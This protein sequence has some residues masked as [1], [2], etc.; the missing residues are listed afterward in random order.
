MDITD[1]LKADPQ[2][3]HPNYFFEPQET[4]RCADANGH[5]HG[6]GS[7]WV[8]HHTYFNQDLFDKAGIKPPGFKDDEI[9][10]RDTFI[11]NAKQLTVDA[12]GKHPDDSR[13]DPDN[14]QQWAVNWEMWWMPIAAAIY[15]NGGEFI[16]KDGLLA[17]DSPE[18]M[19]AMQRLVDLIYV[20]HV[21]PRTASMSDL[22]MTSAQMVDNG[23]LAMAVDGSWALSWLNPAAM[24]VPMGTGAIPKMKKPATV[25]Q[26]HFHAIISSTKHPD[27]AW[28]WLKFLASPFYTLSFMK[29]GLWLPSQSAQVTPDGLKE[30]VTKG[31]HPDNY[32]DFVTEYLPKNGVALRIP[33]GYSEAETSFI[34]PAFQAMSAGTPVA[35]VMP[36]AVK[37]ANEIIKAAQAS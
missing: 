17:I 4:D 32:V 23:R 16:N 35:D 3:S 28:Q 12:N 21:A 2:L 19:E 30:W 14:I 31:I 22:G 34:T 11:A 20:H 29:I 7:T 36:E 8:A 24:K 33:N 5:W 10:D 26:A 27:E 18:A 13:F 37:Q 25:M 1:R 15:S 6:I 9:W